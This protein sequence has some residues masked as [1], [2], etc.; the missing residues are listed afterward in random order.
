MQETPRRKEERELFT[1]KLVSLLV[2]NKPV[3]F[4]DEA[5]WNLWSIADVGN[6]WMRSNDKIPIV[7]NTRQGSGITI[8]GAVSNVLDTIQLMTYDRTDVEGVEI[9]LERLAA[10][11]NALDLPT[12]PY[13]VMDNHAAHH[14]NALEEVFESFEKFYLPAYSSFL[15]S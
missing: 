8:Y 12:K 4:F 11:V 13:L 15:N 10:K 1:K 14:A 7:K 2:T 3:I 5:S 9:F 6:T